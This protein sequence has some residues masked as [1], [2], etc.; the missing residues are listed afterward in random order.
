MPPAFDYLGL[1]VFENAFNTTI[2]YLPGTAN[3][4]GTYCGRPTALW[5]LASPLILWP[6]LTGANGF[7][8]TPPDG[9]GFVVSW[10]TNAFVTVE[11]CTNFAD[12][13]WIPLQTNELIN[14]SFYF[15]DSD[16]T[17][18]PSRFYRLRSP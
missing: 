13:I 17:N 12:P 9:F 15:S 14:G 11:A 5:T 7:P 1:T 3:W 4:V 16:W 8:G 2:Y 18:H 6:S 10:A